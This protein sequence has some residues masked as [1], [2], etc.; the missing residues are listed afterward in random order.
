ML[1]YHT[2]NPWISACG[3]HR[4]FNSL[5]VCRFSKISLIQKRCRRRL[6][7]ALHRFLFNISSSSRRCRTSILSCVNTQTS[8]QL[9]LVVP[10]VRSL[11]PLRKCIRTFRTVLPCVACVTYVAWRW[12]NDFSYEIRKRSVSNVIM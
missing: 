5:R 2:I 9:S 12:K 1:N 11:R 7:V 8:F 4:K 6:Y 10:T 3:V